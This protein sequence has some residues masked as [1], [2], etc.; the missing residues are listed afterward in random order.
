[1][2]LV[3]KTERIGYINI[4]SL[5][6][7]VQFYVQR[8][9]NL[10]GSSVNI[11]FQLERLNVGRAM[12]LTT[13]VFTAPVFGTYFF[14]FSAIKGRNSQFGTEMYLYHNN[15]VIG[16]AFGSPSVH[17]TLS[18]HAVLELKEGDKVYLVKGVGDDIM[19]LKYHDPVKRTT[20]FSGWLLQEGI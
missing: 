14:S 13:G 17:S 15:A 2:R 9:E 5:V 6:R 16:T 20:H 10:S 18:L 12:N 11:T 8:D 19:A 1:L 4:K 3:G 7:G